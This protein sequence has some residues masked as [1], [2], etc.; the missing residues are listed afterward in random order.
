[1]QDRYETILGNRN[2][3]DAGSYYNYGYDKS[4]SSLQFR[5]VKVSASITVKFEIINEK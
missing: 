4:S 5:E 1:L 2:N 3:Y